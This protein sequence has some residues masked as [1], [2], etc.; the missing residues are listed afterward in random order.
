M[1]ETKVA[2]VAVPMKAEHAPKV[3]FSDFMNDVFAEKRHRAYDAI[4]RQTK[5]VEFIHNKFRDSW[6]DANNAE[7]DRR[8]QEQ[9]EA[10][11]K[12]SA[13]ELDARNQARKNQAAQ[14]RDF[15]RQQMSE[16]EKLAEQEKLVREKEFKKEQND[17]ARRVLRS[18]E[19]E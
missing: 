18:R 1:C 15:Q 12:M 14:A 2:G 9:L 11:L 7:F 5:R 16:K 8:I 3:H 10:R 19:L 6:A 4:D 17:L 13:E